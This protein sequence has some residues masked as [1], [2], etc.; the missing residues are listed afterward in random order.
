MRKAIGEGAEAHAR[1]FTSDSDFALHLLKAGL[2]VEVPEALE[3]RG[4]EIG[5]A[6]Y[7]DVFTSQERA[8]AERKFQRAKAAGER[9]RDAKKGRKAS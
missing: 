1:E 9:K 4:L 7:E 2:A 6:A 5:R 3:K 8:K